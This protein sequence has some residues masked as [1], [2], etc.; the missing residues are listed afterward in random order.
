MRFYSPILFLVAAGG[1]YAYNSQQV[2]QALVLPF[3]DWIDASSVGNPARQGQL[4]VQVLLGVALALGVRDAFGW[5]R[6][7][8]S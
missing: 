8:A 1:V 4:T 2:N 6:D 3:M 7:R 5:W